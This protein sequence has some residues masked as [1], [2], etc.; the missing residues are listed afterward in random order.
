MA[1]NFIWLIAGQDDIMS[2]ILPEDEQD[3]LP[4]GFT[5]VG[6]I[7]MFPHLVFPERFN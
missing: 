3:E 1:F 4:S 5:I 7:G 2:S 6:H